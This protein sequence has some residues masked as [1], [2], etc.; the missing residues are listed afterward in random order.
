MR[1][2]REY[3]KHYPCWFITTTMVDWLHLLIDDSYYSVL[4]ESI[5]HY[6]AKYQ[7]DVLGYVWM[8]NHIHIILFF[9]AE[10]RL[11]ELMRDFKKYTAAVIRKKLQEDRR[12][13]VEERLRYEVG[14]QQ[15][16]VWMNRYDAVPLWTRTVLLTKLQYIHS[17]PVKRGLAD[18]EREYK[19]SSA[20]YYAGEETENSVQLRH[21]SNIL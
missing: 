20:A 14:T 19:Y 16:K 9:N 3:S 2:N 11:A 21:I 7:A 18:K 15:Y 6:T 12:C 4:T 10:V 17:N 13:L 8:P 1:R 5:N